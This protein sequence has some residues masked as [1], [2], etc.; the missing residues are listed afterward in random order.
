[1]AC[2]VISQNA[3]EIVEAV[4]EMWIKY[5]G[6]PQKFLSDNGGEFSNDLYTELCHFLNTEVCSTAA[7]SPFSNGIVER[8]NAIIGEIIP[9]LVADSDINCSKDLAVAWACSAKNSLLNH[10]G[11]TPNQLVFGKSIRLPSVATDKLRA[12]ESMS[13]DMIRKK[14]LL[15]H[16]SRIAYLQAESSQRIKRALKHK[17]RTYC[18]VDYQ[19]GDKV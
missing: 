15:M 10:N 16:K 12:L 5:F 4:Y 19:C 18:E 8:H 2:V 7:Y 13:S 17:T 3:P 11:Y 1:M 9:K 14:L 6:C